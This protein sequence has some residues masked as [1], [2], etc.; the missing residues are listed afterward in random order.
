MALT[1][2]RKCAEH[3]TAFASDATCF[4][5][6]CEGR[7]ASCWHEYCELNGGFQACSAGKHDSCMNVRFPK[8]D[9]DE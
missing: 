1:L 7:L 6:G 2:Y 9:E 8:E 4:V 3:D 5:D